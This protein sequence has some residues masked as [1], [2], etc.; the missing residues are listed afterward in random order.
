MGALAYFQGRWEEAVGFYDRFIETKERL[1]DPVHA[2]SGM[3]NR[4]RC[5]AF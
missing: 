5:E 2:A 4:T 3:L 1:G